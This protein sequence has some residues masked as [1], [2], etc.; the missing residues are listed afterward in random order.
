M[1]D[2][3]NREPFGILLRHHRLAIGLTQ[4]R[5][6]ERS[7]VAKRTIQDL[8]RGVARPRR[9]TVR[10]LM[11]VLKLSPEARAGL[12]AVR[13]SRRPRV[14]H[15]SSQGPWA[16]SVETGA[17]A[18]RHHGNLPVPRTRLI[19]REQEVTTTCH[20][21]LRDDVD[22]VTLT[23]PPGTGKTRL[24]L[25]VAAEVSDHFPDGAYFVALAPI[26]NPELVP[27]DH[28]PGPGDPRCRGPTG[29]G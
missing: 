19:G 28:R 20:L 6:A 27:A 5:L 7:G 13:R 3:H 24:G 1:S 11:D 2:S 21:L 23:G 10:R 16:Q 22:L 26:A 4:E 12:E 8:E 14:A 29:P 18:Q 25:Q 15:S 9:E 17:S